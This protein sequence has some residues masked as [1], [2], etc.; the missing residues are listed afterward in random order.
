MVVLIMMSGLR[1]TKKIGK[2]NI[3]LLKNNCGIKEFIDKR[4]LKMKSTKGYWS[5][6][7]VCEEI[8]ETNG[9][10]AGVSAKR[11]ILENIC[12]IYDEQNYISTVITDIRK[13][14]LSV[15][16]FEKDIS[17]NNKKGNI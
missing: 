15:K 6:K 12:N 7:E 4:L 17:S 14:K 5:M 8:T 3:M 16:I 1:S 2:H 9:Q 11:Y 13:M 10:E